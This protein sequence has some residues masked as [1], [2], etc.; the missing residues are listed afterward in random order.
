MSKGQIQKQLDVIRKE[1]GAKD[2]IIIPISTL[3]KLN[4]YEVWDLF[5]NIFEANEFDIHLERQNDSK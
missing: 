4:K 5:N 1:L 2:R 3:S